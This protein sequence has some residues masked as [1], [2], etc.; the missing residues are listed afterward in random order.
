MK[1][2][3]VLYTRV[4]TNKDEQKS[5]LDNQKEM[6][7]QYCKSRGFELVDVYADV[8]TGTNVR[9]RPNFIRMIT[10]GG[11]DHVKSDV[12]YDEFKMSNR[13]PK[14]DYIIVKDAPRFSRNQHIGLLTLEYLRNKGVYVIFEN[15]GLNTESNDWHERATMMFMMAQTE[16][17]NMG[18]R[19]AFTKRFNA[20][21]GIYRPAR[22]PYGYARDEN[23]EFIIKEDEARIIRII[24]RLF[25]R[26]GGHRISRF[27]NQ[28]GIT[29]QQ[30]KKW[31]SDK[32][33]RIIRNTGYYGNPTVNR[34]IKKNV[35]DTH[36]TDLPKNEHIEIE[37]GL[38][39]IVSREVWDEAN[40]IIASR[41][42]KNKTRGR[43]PARNDIYYEKLYCEKCGSRFIRHIGNGKKINYICMNRRKA[44]GCDVRGISIGIVD[45]M[46]ER[47]GSSF[48]MDGM[49]N[50]IGYKQ[51]T[52]RIEEEIAK[53]SERRNTITA[54][55]EE[56][57]QENAVTLI[58]IKE[59]FK[60]GSQTVIDMLTKD[61]EEKEQRIKQLEAKRERL[62]INSVVQLKEKVEAKRQLI[63]DI[64]QHRDITKDERL[65]LLDR[66]IVGDYSCTISFNFP[67]F[68]DEIFE[69]NSIFPMAKINSVTTH[70]FEETIR[71]EHKE[72]RE[73]WAEY[74]ENI[75]NLDHSKK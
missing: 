40:S 66:I 20:T 74:D 21:K 53:L 62:N 16:S 75:A 57:Q 49:A 28:R 69:F 39:P 64:H 25:K 47:V 60:G 33:I 32:I 24:F 63:E 70:K 44:Q 48:L 65:K 37:N 61:I 26:K 56:L 34:S 30:G 72:A 31:S 1:K 2:R 36:R 52:N 59:Q 11:L 58:G 71:R 14:F 41:T 68:E 46:F 73:F 55:I 17:K 9:R 6:Y 35:T 29:T 13:N 18:Q 50:H 27:L 3:A 12:G 67:T 45:E 42:N 4:S 15:V 22:L 8:G 51:L 43:K 7:K 38:P 10:D 19:I 23:N 54:E 5:S